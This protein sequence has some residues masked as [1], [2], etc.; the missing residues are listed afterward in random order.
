MKSVLSLVNIY[1]IFFINGAL[2]KTVPG[3]WSDWY[4]PN[5]AGDQKDGIVGQDIGRFN[6]FANTFARYRKLFVSRISMINYF[7]LLIVYCCRRFCV[8]HKIKLE[9][10]YVLG[11]V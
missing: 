5:S 7:T 2:G 8:E 3:P 1:S 4:R 6:F 10:K 9:F 11:L